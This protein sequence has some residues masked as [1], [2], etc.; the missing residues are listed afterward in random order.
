MQN[1]EGLTPIEQELEH[2]LRGVRPAEHGESASAAC[3]LA[4]RLGRASLCRRVRVWQG[5]S[6]A[7]GLCLVATVTLGPLLGEWG[8][9]DPAAHPSVADALGVVPREMAPAVAG[10]PYPGSV[11]RDNRAIGDQE[12]SNRAATGL[13]ERRGENAGRWSPKGYA[14]IRDAVLARGVDA[15]PDDSADPEGVGRGSTKTSDTSGEIL[16]V[17]GVEFAI[18]P[19]AAVNH[20]TPFDLFMQ[21]MST[22]E[23]P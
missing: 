6:G 4:F 23:T 10:L 5:V 12:A 20:K 19:P 22:G 13:E 1:D 3:D 21:L 7:I 2:A 15:L 9:P 14:R 11:G 16:E 18:R 8:T 17:D